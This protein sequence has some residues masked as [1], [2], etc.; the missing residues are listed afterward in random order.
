MFSTPTVGSAL[1]F[2]PI[3][4]SLNIRGLKC[5]APKVVSNV[6]LMNLENFYGLYWLIISKRPFLIS[7][8]FKLYLVYGSMFFLPKML[9]TL[10]LNVMHVFKFEKIAHP[11]IF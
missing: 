9:E 3:L 11:I 7:V 1:W 2:C 6:G 10:Q 8:F 5:L 4:Y